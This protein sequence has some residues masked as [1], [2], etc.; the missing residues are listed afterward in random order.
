MKI[1]WLSSTGDN[2][3]KIYKGKYNFFKVEESGVKSSLVSKIFIVTI[4]FI[5]PFE[6]SLCEIQEKFIF[7]EKIIIKKNFKI[8]GIKNDYNIRYIR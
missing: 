1:F 3:F 2:F 8:K 4:R 5:Y 6:I 7:T